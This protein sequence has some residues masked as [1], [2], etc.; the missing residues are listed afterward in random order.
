MYCVYGNQIQFKPIWTLTFNHELWY[1]ETPID[2]VVELQEQHVETH[3]ACYFT[4][5]VNKEDTQVTWYKNDEPIIEG[6]KHTVNTEGRRHSLL[7]KDVDKDDMASYSV[8][9]SDKKSTA[10]L[11][12]DGMLYVGMQ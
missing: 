2:I 9:V 4:C 3:N 12:L 11:Y 1:P 5:E 6:T 10:K 7:I 8:A